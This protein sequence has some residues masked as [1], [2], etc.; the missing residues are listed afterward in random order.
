M[1][2][3][4][5]KKS[6]NRSL[7]R[8]CMYIA[9]QKNTNSFEQSIVGEKAENVRLTNLNSANLY[10]AFLEMEITQSLNIRSKSDKNY[11]LIV[12]F[13][14]GEKPSD[15]VLEDIENN[16][17]QRIGLGDHQRISIVHNDTDHYHFHVLINKVHPISYNNIEPFYD[18]KD[19][20]KACTDMEVKHGLIKT[21]HKET[22]KNKLI[23]SE[24]FR[25]EE[26]LI[27]YLKGNSESIKNLSTWDSVHEF[28][29]SLGVRLKKR[30]AGLVF[31]DVS[32]KINVKASSI[33]R[34]FSLKKL[35]TQL[36]KFEDGGNIYD[37][38]ES[39]NSNSR[40][41]RSDT[42]E[43]NSG[44]NAGS[45]GNGAR[46]TSG[47]IY[48]QLQRLYQSYDRESADFFKT[49]SINDV[50]KLSSIIMDGDTE[51]SN[52]FLS[53]NEV[54]NVHEREP[55]RNTERVRRS[56]KSFSN[57]GSVNK[58]DKNRFIKSSVLYDQYKKEVNNFFLSK[59]KLGIQQKNEQIRF[60][61]TLNN[62][63]ESEKKLIKLKGGSFADRKLKYQALSVRSKKLRDQFYSKQAKERADLPNK[64]SWN[65]YLKANVLAN[66]E[67]SEIALKTLRKQSDKL[68][69]KVELEFSG[70][71][72]IF[73]NFD[74][75]VRLNGTIAYSLASK[76]AVLDRSKDLKIE[77]VDDKSV[78]LALL[79][80][81]EK[82]ND[83]PLKINGSDEF[84][85]MVIKVIND[86][87]LQV[88]LRDKELNDRLI[89]RGSKANNA[90]E[91][92]EN[93]KSKKR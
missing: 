29:K 80:A 50:R 82:F 7:K 28:S 46:G 31:E 83:R 43:S 2:A 75:K 21:N 91:A 26:S 16:L 87:G 77:K 47:F 65:E 58:Y 93:I 40:G 4:R 63:I 53:D 33:F 25:N 44:R 9:D 20:M 72:S 23:E 74:S 51:K 6:A 12:S 24:I 18:K 41:R 42:G 48:E 32:S 1:I 84:K 52:V 19:L 17:V 8:T 10:D 67:Y 62:W 45:N 79:V 70:Q 81:K 76:P 55:R 60:K 73:S 66:N 27:H 69:S 39:N 36:G 30:G 5:A 64:P 3:K 14:V 68:I 11:H 54:E 15:Q 92:A 78:L 61:A 86:N 88:T 38:R 57:D 56:G 35:E 90:E 37:R 89:G 13:P 49:E 59:K 85:N 34:E 22:K 71:N